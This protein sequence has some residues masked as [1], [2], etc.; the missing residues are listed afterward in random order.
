[1]ASGVRCLRGRVQSDG[2]TFAD[3]QQ[4]CAP[5]LNHHAELPEPQREALNV[6]LAARGSAPDRFRRVSG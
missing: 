4:L 5:L 1:M 3:L 2:F 6:A